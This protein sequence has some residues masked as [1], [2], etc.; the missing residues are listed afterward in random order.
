VSDTTIVNPNMM[1]IRYNLLMLGYPSTTTNVNINYGV[2]TWGAVEVTYPNSFGYDYQLSNGQVN[3]S[4]AN[5]LKIG[6]VYN[7]VDTMYISWQYTDVSSQVH[8]GLDKVDNSSSAA[9][10]FNLRSLIFDGGTV[11]K[12]KEA[13]RLQITFNTLPAGVTIIPFYSVNRGADVLGTAATVGTQ[14]VVLELG[15]V[16]FHELQWGLTG[17]LTAGSTAPTITGVTMEVGPLP[18]E[19]NISSEVVE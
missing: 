18:E 17:T 14:K 13:Y 10:S 19:R 2:Y 7:Y 6:A 16:R 4:A 9:T 15:A 5:N 1:A 8:Y 3:Y 11:F 12:T